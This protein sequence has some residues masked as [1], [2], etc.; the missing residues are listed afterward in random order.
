MH[1]SNKRDFSQSC[2]VQFLRGTILHLSSKAH[3]QGEE[4]MSLWEVIAFLEAQ[5]IERKSCVAQAQE[6]GRN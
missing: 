3:L 6:F 2:A 5:S 1:E 4:R